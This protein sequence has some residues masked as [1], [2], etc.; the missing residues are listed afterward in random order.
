MD[1]N[2][3][4]GKLEVVSSLLNGDEEGDFFQLIQQ[5]LERIKEHGGDI[6]DIK[7][8]VIFVFHTIPAITKGTQ[9][10]SVISSFNL[11]SLRRDIEEKGEN[12][13]ERAQ[14]IIAHEIAHYVLNNYNKGPSDEIERQTDD[15]IVEKWG[16]NRAYTDLKWLF[17]DFQIANK[18]RK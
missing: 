2:T 10:R 15:Y 18:K 7:D 17:T 11:S 14:D 9:S 8:N 4:R 3:E 13:E 16:F 5:T 1:K 12:F 6:D